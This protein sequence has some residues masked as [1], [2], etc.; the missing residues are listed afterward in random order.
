[1]H[2]VEGGSSWQVR[3]AVSHVHAAYIFNICSSLTNGNGLYDTCNNDLSLHRYLS[4]AEGT[5]LP[6]LAMA[7]LVGRHFFLLGSGFLMRLVYELLIQVFLWPVIIAIPHRD[8]MQPHEAHEWSLTG[9]TVLP[10]HKVGRVTPPE[11]SVSSSTLTDA[12]RVPAQ[13]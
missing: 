10:C 12:L 1:M 4:F 6:L 5:P 11:A 13:R 2:A 8:Y 7:L 9:T 3:A